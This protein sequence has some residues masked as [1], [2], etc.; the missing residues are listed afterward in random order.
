MG[1]GVGGVVAVGE[2]C[3]VAVG[4]VVGVVC[5]TGVGVG[6]LAGD[7]CPVMNFRPKNVPPATKTKTTRAPITSNS[8]LDLLC[9]PA[10]GC[11]YGNTGALALETGLS[12]PETPALRTS[13]A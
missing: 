9:C 7:D 5:T 8:V 10:G 11:T 3:A 1:V 13:G 4:L 2:G 12:I 6:E